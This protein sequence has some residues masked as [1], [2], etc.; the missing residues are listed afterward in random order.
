[1][2]QTLSEKITSQNNAPTQTGVHVSRR[3]TQ[4]GKDPLDDVRW[5]KRR[6]VIANPDGSTVF[7]MEGVEVPAQWSPRHG[8]RGE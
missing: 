7:A 3:F 1:M 5:E 4:K 2:S 6:T 8:H